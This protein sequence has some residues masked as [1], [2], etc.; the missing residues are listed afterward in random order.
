[1]KLEETLRVLFDASVEFVLIGGAA[2]QMQG[3]AHLTEDLD[4]CY[5]RSEKNMERLALAL[6]P[7]HPKLRGA[8]RLDYIPTVQAV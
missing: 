2:M 3:S 5:A 7:Y 4:F 1:V 6:A 8:T